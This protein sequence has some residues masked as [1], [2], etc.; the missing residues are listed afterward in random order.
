MTQE[1][2]RIRQLG[3]GLAV[4][5]P[6]SGCYVVAVLGMRDWGNLGGEY[7]EGQHPRSKFKITHVT[8]AVGVLPRDEAEFDGRWYQGAPQEGDSGRAPEPSHPP[9][10]LLAGVMGAVP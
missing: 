7:G 8:I 2:A 4:S 9:Y 10:L 1:G 6:D 3:D 5:P